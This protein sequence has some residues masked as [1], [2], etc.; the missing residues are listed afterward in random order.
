MHTGHGRSDAHCELH[1]L[2]N[3]ARVAHLQ[4]EHLHVECLDCGR[5]LQLV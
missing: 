3:A 4:R 2:R 5:R 1:D